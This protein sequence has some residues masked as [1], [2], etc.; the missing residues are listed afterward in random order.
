MVKD[1]KSGTYICPICGH[2][3]RKKQ[4]SQ[5]PTP[6]VYERNHQQTPTPKP[7]PQQPYP[8][9][10]Y[11]AYQY[12][13]S[14]YQQ[15]LYSQSYHHTPYPPYTR[16]RLNA[17]TSITAGLKV[18][19]QN[20]GP[21]LA[22]YTPLFLVILSLSLLSLSSMGMFGMFSG[23]TQ[24]PD[25]TVHT[26]F[27]F[28][29]WFFTILITLV[30]AAAMGLFFGGGASMAK[31]AYETGKTIPSTGFSI[32]SQRAPY[33]IG[34]YVLFTFVVTIGTM[35]CLIPGL[36]FCYWWLFAVVIIALEGHG[37]IDAF[38]R[39]KDF[40]ERNDT[41][42]FTIVVFALMLAITAVASVPVSILTLK[43]GGLSATFLWLS[44]AVSSA[45]QSYVAFPIFVNSVTVHYLR[46]R[47]GRWWG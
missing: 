45:V 22:Y 31:E 36:L 14:Q 35:A 26:L 15:Y 30:E 9:H 32:I 23:T 12:P 29:Y 24:T 2:R 5:Q 38:G 44:Q 46:G 40:A 6:P 41:L 13:A 34:G 1:T 33:L 21:F 20:I 42:I 39:S 10:Q 4:A 27:S 43:G 37:I 47:T 3:E 19:F 11:P 18:Y 25:V 16:Q 8:T 7:P 28:K 17:S